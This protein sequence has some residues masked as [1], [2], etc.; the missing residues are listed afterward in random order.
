M[1]FKNLQVF[2]LTEALNVDAAGLDDVLAQRVLREC[3]PQEPRNLGW[4]SPVAQSVEANEQPLVHSV[5][6]C[7][8][9]AMG[10]EERL[11]PASVVRE[12]LE[13]RI[14]LAEQADGKKPSRKE[15]TAIK[16]EIE[17]E[18]MPR[19]FTRR[20][21]MHALIDPVDGWVIVDGAAANRAEE[22]LTLLRECLGSLKVLPLQQEDVVRDALTQWLQAGDLPAG[23]EIGFDCE[24]RETGED[25]GVIRCAN[26]NL[27]GE[28][29][30][31]ALNVGRVVSRLGLVWQER[32]SFLLNDKAAFLRL[33]FLDQLQEQ[34]DEME[35]DSRE[36][37]FTS[38]MTLMIGEIRPLLLSLSGVL[39]PPA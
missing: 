34:L 10:S 22:L 17:F 8:I 31:N 38:I 1:W 6:G 35:P 3:G 36:M 27:H 33:K 37:E 30:Q 7:M 24:L 21:R 18:L 39:S 4:V 25:N 23:L 14:M 5:S 19:A 20:K 11:L 32:V 16:E 2:K 12:E 13:E 15:R 29:V 26:F 9:I 28:E